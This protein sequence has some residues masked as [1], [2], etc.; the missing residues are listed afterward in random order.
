MSGE[1]KPVIASHLPTSYAQQPPLLNSA[2][3]SHIPSATSSNF[4]SDSSGFPPDSAHSYTSN[5]L[6]KQQ[7]L[8]PASLTHSH[9]SHHSHSLS[10]STTHSQPPSNPLP[11]TVQP[12]PQASVD[13]SMSGGDGKKAGS[14]GPDKG[15]PHLCNICNRGFTTGGHLQR[16]QRIH[17]GVKAFKCPFPGCETRTSRQDNLQQQ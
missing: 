3:S 5:P 6:V 15:K 1:I 13:D 2:P 7:Q 9:N 11:L 14:T 8:S 4:Q 10:H 16:H 17:T 12:Q